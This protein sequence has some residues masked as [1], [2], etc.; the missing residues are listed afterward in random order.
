VRV[1]QMAETRAP[2]KQSVQSSAECVLR[3][4]AHTI[5]Y[6][7]STQHAA[8][9]TLLDA[10]TCSYRCFG[11]MA[12]VHLEQSLNSTLPSLPFRSYQI[13]RSFGVCADISFLFLLCC[14]P[15]LDSTS[16]LGFTSG[17]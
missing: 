5:T 9:S 2:L 15:R 4:I 6:T 8:R 1:G 7:R 12:S 16:T 14:S 10:P 17:F 3:A 11:G 13:F